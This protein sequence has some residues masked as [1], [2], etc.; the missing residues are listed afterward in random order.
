MFFVLY[1]IPPHLSPHSMIVTRSS[2][3]I[4]S[5]VWPS[6]RIIRA[7][8][9]CVCNGWYN[10]WWITLVHVCTAKA[11]LRS[12]Q[13]K[14][15]RI[16]IIWIYYTLHFWRIGIQKTILWHLTAFW[17]EISKHLYNPYYVYYPR[18]H[19][20]VLCGYERVKH[21]AYKTQILMYTRK[22]CM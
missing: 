19:N 18:E 6:F 8:L 1:A 11:V 13:L 2:Y 22:R 4:A 15:T 9:T 21:F 16:D 14:Y 17:T 10:E 3:K 7:P 12:E 20:I 5:R